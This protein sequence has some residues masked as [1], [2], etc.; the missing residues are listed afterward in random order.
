V[1]KWISVAASAVIGVAL[2]AVAAWGVVSANTSAPQ[3]NPAGAQIVDYG[4]R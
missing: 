4:T 3:H 1:G 2:A